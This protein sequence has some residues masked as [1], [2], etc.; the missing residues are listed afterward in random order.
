[1]IRDFQASVIF[2]PHPQLLLAVY[3]R[4]RIL[5]LLK[6]KYN[7]N[8]GELPADPKL[9]LVLSS[10]L[11]TAKPALNNR[12]VGVVHVNIR[13]GSDREAYFSV[14]LVLRRE[15]VPS[16]HEGSRSAASS[17]ILLGRGS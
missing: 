12:P 17:S 10:L 2:P 8:L 3:V 15:V 16:G 11:S 9:L 1:M 4:Q 13:G 14:S 7:N 5:R 6:N